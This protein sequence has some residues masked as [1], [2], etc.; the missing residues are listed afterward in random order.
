M[1]SVQHFIFREFS[2]FLSLSESAFRSHFQKDILIH[3]KIPSEESAQAACESE[4]AEPQ[5]GHARA[6]R[7]VHRKRVVRKIR[8]PRSS[9]F[10]VSF[11]AFFGVFLSSHYQ[12]HPIVLQN[13][14]NMI[15]IDCMRK[16]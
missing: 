1:N 13:M 10:V 6:A 9:F 8:M 16:K 12:V 3:G 4:L 7:G 5:A 11:L 14:R 2:F 15:A